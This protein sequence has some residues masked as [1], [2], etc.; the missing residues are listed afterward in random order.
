MLFIFS[1]CAKIATPLTKEEA[2][3]TNAPV[4]ATQPPAEA[5]SEPAATTNPPATAPAPAPAP[6]PAK[7][8]APTPA[9]TEAPAQPKEQTVL[10][11]AAGFSPAQVNISQ[12]STII[13][14][15]QD[16]VPHWPASGVHPTHQLCPGFDALQPLEQGQAYS[17]TFTEAKTCPM[18]DHL[19]PSVRGNIIIE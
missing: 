17:F 7:I 5:P 3:T 1:A 10:M 2:E 19:N 15:N 13:F 14:V 16:S 8:E 6:A 12:G 9:L 11:T 4:E 18:H